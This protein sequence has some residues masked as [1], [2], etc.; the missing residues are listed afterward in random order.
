M[1]VVFVVIGVRKGME[2]ERKKRR[3]YYKGGV[4]WSGDGGEKVKN[5]RIQK[6]KRTK[7]TRAPPVV[8]RLTVCFVAVMNMVPFIRADTHTHTL[9]LT[10][11]R[12]G[13]V[14]ILAKWDLGPPLIRR[15]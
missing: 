11:F 12:H 5:E 8:I 10:P 9:V 6:R 3:L 1:D 14:R 4:V 13:R 7:K 15:P 2:K